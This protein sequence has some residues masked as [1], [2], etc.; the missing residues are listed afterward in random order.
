MRWAFQ[1][2]DYDVVIATVDYAL[3]ES[4][5]FDPTY[6]LAYRYYRAL[7]LEAQ[8]EYNEAAAEY[9]LI[10]ETAPESAWGMLAKLHLED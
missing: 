6:T 9:A 8:G 10:Y 4:D 1:D 3:N 2:E 7:S 5:L